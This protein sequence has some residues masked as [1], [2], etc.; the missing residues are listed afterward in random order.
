[1][2]AEGKANKCSMQGF[3]GFYLIMFAMY[4]TDLHR[5]MG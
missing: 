1:M 5:S 2:G 3:A 4:Y